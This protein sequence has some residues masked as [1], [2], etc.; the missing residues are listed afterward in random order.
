MLDVERWNCTL[1]HRFA[2]CTWKI[3]SLQERRRVRSLLSFALTR[4]QPTQLGQHN[5]TIEI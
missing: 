3:P 4:L 5:D 1:R 2:R